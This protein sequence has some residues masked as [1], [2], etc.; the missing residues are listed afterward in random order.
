[1]PIPLLLLSLLL[2]TGCGSA[3]E[4]LPLPAPPDGSHAPGVATYPVLLLLPERYNPIACVCRR[5]A[6]LSRRNQKE[7]P[8]LAGATVIDAAGMRFA[9]T[10]ARPVR[11]PHHPLAQLLFGTFVTG[12]ILDV[13]FR[14]RPIGM[15]QSSDI[16]AA[17]HDYHDRFRACGLRGGEPVQTL[18]RGFAN[19]RCVY[20]PLWRET[21]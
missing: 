21:D 15:A 17:M 7:V 3:L 1:M 20:P 9:V 2:L 14:L 5:P 4:S 6:D 19:G 18:L 12:E 13:P 16:W 10:A 11:D 8:L